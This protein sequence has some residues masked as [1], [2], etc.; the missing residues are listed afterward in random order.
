[1]SFIPR[2]LFIVTAAV[3]GFG[4]FA[5]ADQSCFEAGKLVVKG[6][7]L[8]DGSK[9]EEDL[10]EEAISKCPTMAEAYY[11]LGVLRFGKGEF[12]LAAEAFEQALSKREDLLFLVSKGTA[13]LADNKPIDA[14]EEFERALNL[15][16][17]SIRASVG[18][19]IALDK[20]GSSDKAKDL[21]LKLSE[22]GERDELLLYNLAVIAFRLGDYSLAEKSYLDILAANP[23]HSKAAEGLGFLYLERREYERAKEYLTKAVTQSPD[24]SEL[25]RALSTIYVGEGEWEKAELALRRVLNLKANDLDALIQLAK[26]NL[27]RGKPSEAEVEIRRALEV[28]ADSAV[29]LAVLGHALL[30]LERYADSERAFLRSIELDATDPVTFNNLAVLY[31]KQGESEKAAEAKKKAELLSTAQ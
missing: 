3:I 31:Q 30:D 6:V 15:D 5:W 7:R 28:K 18:L 17:A 29:A 9:N 12:S 16:P 11:N 19:S 27:R 23:G 20:H 22:K 26:L 1:M 2:S 24:R 25:H 10:Y 14:K 8:G 4:N 13:L 21:L